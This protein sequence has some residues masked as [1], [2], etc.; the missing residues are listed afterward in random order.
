[1]VYEDELGEGLCAIKKLKTWLAMA[2]LKVQKGCTKGASGCKQCCRRA[3]VCNCKICGKLF[4]GVTH[5]KVRDKP[6]SRQELNGMLKEL[7]CDLEEAGVVPP[8]TAK[9]VSGIL[10]RAGG[11]TEAAACGME[12][13]LLAGHGRWKSLSGPEAYDRNDKRKFERVSTVLQ[14]SLRQTSTQRR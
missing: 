10:L 6:L 3:C 4:R 1:M 11:V 7:F 2:H 14:E 12:K 13:R 9:E 8:G 5:G